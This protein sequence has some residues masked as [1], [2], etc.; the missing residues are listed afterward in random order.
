MRGKC[1][2][3]AGCCE[4]D[5]NYM[6]DISKRLDAIEAL[7]A[8]HKY[9]VINRA[10]QFGKTTML[11]LLTRRLSEQYAVFFLSF[12][13]IG[14]SDYQDEASFCRMVCGLMAEEIQD[15]LVSGVDADMQKR[16]EEIASDESVK[17][18]FR[19]L[20]AVLTD[21]CN[22]AA[23]PV[24]LMID[25][26]DQASSSE[27]FLT[28]LGML[29]SKYL[30][31]ARRRTFQAVVLAGLYDI[32]NLKLRI[33]SEEE[34]KY[35]SPWNIAARF[36]VEMSFSV[37]DIA[38]MLEQYE[39]DKHTGMHINEVAECIYGYTSGY[40][41]LVSDICKMLDEEIPSEARFAGGE[42]VWTE[43]GISEAVKLIIKEPR[44]S[45]FE[46]MM[47]QL[48]LFP[49]LRLLLSGILYQG[50]TIPYSPLNEAVN[51]GMMFGFLKEKNGVVVVSNRIF[52]MVLL[53]LFISEEASRSEAYQVGM[54][55]KNQFVKNGFLDMDAVMSKFVQYYTEVFGSNDEKFVE[56]KGRKLFLLYLK[57][58][59]NGTG[60]AYMESATRDLE[61]T[62][63][64]IDYL[65]EQYIIE[66][67]I[68]RGDSYHTRGEQQ[69]CGY[70][71]AY[72][73]K[74]GYMLSFNFN[75]NKQPGVQV[76][77][78]GDKTIV[79]AVV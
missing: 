46:S 14:D 52:E 25:E 11:N 78:I 37:E 39:M 10:R 26:V 55:N 12:E 66:M 8:E 51:L 27:Q 41:V 59:I 38:G 53:N 67:K 50:K 31:R 58:I 43:A 24:V 79:E 6:V 1:F 30:R 16:L 72:H 17:I 76:I 36:D 40:P 63:L 44:V 48:E 77:Q 47:K 29:R 2:N 7:I 15:G 45:L 56:E 9:F 32:R 57:P 73:K 74:K 23:K 22:T 68:W 18:N 20:S 4:P 21:L 5:E 13:G 75:K 3:V 71:D 62:D 69:I 60:N 49:E 35:N 64:I 42:K 70:L 65:G 54:L 19:I 34:H 28:F 33:R 61:R